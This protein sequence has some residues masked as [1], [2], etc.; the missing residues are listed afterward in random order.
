MIRNG[1]A[2]KIHSLTECPFAELLSLPWFTSHGCERLSFAAH[3]R[4]KRR[5]IV[6]AYP[7]RLLIIKVGRSRADM[8]EKNGEVEYP[9]EDTPGDQSNGKEE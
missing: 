1:Y 5:D 8:R 7:L 3:N 6:M 4:P 9:P 2:S